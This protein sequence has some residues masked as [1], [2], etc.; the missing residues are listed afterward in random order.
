[1]AENEYN[2]SEYL[3]NVDITETLHT[4][5]HYNNYF[6]TKYLEETI[7]IYLK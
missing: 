2:M 5:F 4:K 1:M 3:Q 6:I 7:Y